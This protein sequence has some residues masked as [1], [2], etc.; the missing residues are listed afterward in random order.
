MTVVETP[1]SREVSSPQLFESSRRGDS[2]A[3]ETLVVR[4][5]PLARRLAR[6]YARSSLP[7]EDLNQVANLALV[8]AVDRYDPDRGRTFEAFAIPTILGE[9]RRFFRDTSWSV[10][11]ARSAQE[12]SKAIQEAVAALSHTSGRAPTVQQ[13]AQHMEVSQEQ[14]LDGLE[15]LQAYTATSLDAPAQDD[16]ESATVGSTIGSVDPG[17]ELVE[18]D[19]LVEHALEDVTP[20]E[21]LL[22]RLRFVEELPQAE[23]GAR[24]GVS[25]MQVSR[26]LRATLTKLEE[27]IGEIADS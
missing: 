19:M 5:M 21:R 26:L 11:V 24:L 1:A 12:R 10:H 14:V 2:S 9:L 16:E 13:I 27:Q 20:R 3:R 7:L 18:E 25:Q 22:L 15:V 6:R 8:K 23:I 17:Y 4:Y